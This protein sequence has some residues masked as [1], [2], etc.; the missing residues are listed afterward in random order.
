MLFREGQR[1]ACASF[2]TVDPMTIFD[3]LHQAESA[4][5]DEALLANARNL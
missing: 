5:V 2:G 4:L 1:V 3:T